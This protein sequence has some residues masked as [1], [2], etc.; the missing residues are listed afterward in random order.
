MAILATTRPRRR[1]VETGTSLAVLASVLA[2]ACWL[3]ATPAHAQMLQFPDR[4]ARPKRA[5]PPGEQQQMLLQAT[6]IQYDYS[7]KR[8]SAVGNVQIYHKGSTL[9]ANKVVYEE[10]TKRMLAEGNVRLTEPDGKITYAEV[11][12]LSDDFRDGF[13]D[14]LRLDTP[15]Q[16]RMAATRADRTSGNFTV[17]HSGVYTA[18]EPCKD[19]PKK[20]PLWQVK[21]ARMIH[22]E[23]EKMIY[24]ENARLEFFGYPMAYFPYFSAP[25]PTVK[26]K[27]GVLMPVASFSGKYGFGLEVPYYWAL[28]PDYD[29]TLTPRVTSKQGLLLQGEYR[30]RLTNGAFTVRGAGIYQ[31]DKN[32]FIRN[33][34]SPATPGYTDWRGSIETSGQFALNKNWVWG[35]DALALSDRT[36]WQ[37]YGL[38]AFRNLDPFRTGLT[39]GVSQLYVTGKG[40]RSYFDTRAIHFYGFSEADVQ[41]QLPIIHP[42]MDY[43]YVFANPVFG[44]QLGYNV[45]L[46]S[47][48]RES[49]SLDPISQMAVINGACAPTSADPTQKTPANCLMRGIPGTYTRFT[50]E[51]NW[52]RTFTDPYGQQ[53]TPFMNLRGDAAAFSVK[54]D[55]GVSN[56]SIT[57]G[58]HTE[59]RAMPTAGVEYRYPFVNVQS[60]GTH[61][62][63]PIAQIIVRP[64]EPRIGKLPNEDA[65]SLIF[66]DGNLF[67][68]DKFSGY[69]RMEGGGRANVGVQYTTQFNRGGFVNAMFGQSYHLFGTN[70]FSAGDITNTG[71]GSGLDKT[72][73]DYVAR[74]SYQPDRTYTFSTRYRF[75]EQTFSL[76][77]FETEVRANF[78]RWSV[79]AL[80]G[81]YDAQPQLGFL[82]RR[83]GILGQTSIKLNANWVANVAARYDLDASKFDQTQFGIGYIDDCLILGLNYITSYS[84][85]GNAQI[86]HRV[87]LQL[88]LRTLGGTAVTQTVGGLPGGL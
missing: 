40:D 75:D 25:D 60:W 4:P 67:R 9:E 22:D 78:D 31:L 20:P 61:T 48:S 55:L 15:D 52:K 5:E 70:S 63:E 30:Q 38:G 13:V 14:S 18:C 45:N 44:G 33:G 86:D 34:G 39:E 74:V 19:D 66:D 71:L 29:F 6:E 51:T 43:N 11:M 79:S 84:Y 65:Q 88:S 59:L 58:D 53:F 54:S 80:Y 83:E 64:N 68:I 76:R 82:N 50:A 49:V 1:R 23:G 26:R 28:A 24:F 2:V 17:F 42:V 77:R 62:L 35:F 37:D 32:E 56:Y 69:D 73:S 85:S 41:R 21:A 57:P 10:T 47:L 87:M 3:D 46:T 12:N 81:S 72:R 27:T 7:N 16:T 36:F 8:V